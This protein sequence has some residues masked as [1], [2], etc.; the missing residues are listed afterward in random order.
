MPPDSSRSHRSI[1]SLLQASDADYRLAFRY[2]DTAGTGTISFDQF[3]AVYHANTAQTA[4]IPFDLAPLKLYFGES[5]TIGCETDTFSVRCRTPADGAALCTDN[6]FSQLLKGL[7]DE[8]LRQAFAH[9]DKTRSGRISG[10]DFKRIVAETA[11]HKVSDQVLEQV[12]TLTLLASGGKISFSEVVAF[13]NILRSTR[14][15]ESLLKAGECTLR[16]LVL[17]PPDPPP[18]PVQP[19]P[20]PKTA[21][22]TSTTSSTRRLMGLRSRRWRRA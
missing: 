18:P 8:R 9:F 14:A 3:K 4:E 15:I 19:S 22:S 5:D 12:P 17:T 16:A 20:T 7:Q 10:D 21:E 11:K 6:D 2:F 13:Y 1:A